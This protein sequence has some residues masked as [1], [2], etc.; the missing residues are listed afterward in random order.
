MPQFNLTPQQV[1]AITTA[2][3][4]QTE[5]GT[6][7]TRSLPASLATLL[8]MRKTR[9]TLVRRPPAPGGASMP[10]GSI[11]GFRTLSPRGQGRIE[12]NQHMTDD[13]ARL[14]TAFLM[15]L[16]A[17]GSKEATRK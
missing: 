7:F 9:A 10:L 12:P 15:S 1:D 16:S 6:S 13:E 17:I 14:L 3:L 5:D 8:I 11:I 4:A 2:L